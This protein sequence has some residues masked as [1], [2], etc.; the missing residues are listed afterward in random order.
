MVNAHTQ[1]HGLGSSELN[2]GGVLVVNDPAMR[3]HLALAHDNV[4]IKDAMLESQ[5]ELIASLKAG[6]RT[7]KPV[8]KAP[9][10]S[11]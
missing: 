6:C 9:G 4:R 8:L 2:V 11:A 5:A 1:T 10:S 3:S 7:F